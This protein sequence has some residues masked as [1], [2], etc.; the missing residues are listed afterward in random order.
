VNPCEGVSARTRQLIAEQIK[1]RQQKKESEDGKQTGDNASFP[2]SLSSGS[3]NSLISYQPEAPINSLPITATAAQS[4]TNT[5]SPLNQQLSPVLSLPSLSNVVGQSLPGVA[6]MAPSLF[7]FTLG[8]FG[9]APQHMATGSPD[10]AL[11]YS[12]LM[13]LSSF[14]S[15]LPTSILAASLTPVSSISQSPSND[16]ATVGTALYSYCF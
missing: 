8:G 12:K 14:L 2:L 9:L 10:P 1:L 7:N 11:D 4:T 5:T 16:H 15:Q 3:S 6:S 13:S